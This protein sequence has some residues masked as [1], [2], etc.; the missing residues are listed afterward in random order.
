MVVTSVGGK[1]HR[2][3][4][5]NGCKRKEMLVTWLNKPFVLSGY[6]PIDRIDFLLYIR[7]IPVSNFSPITYYVKEDFIDLF[8]FEFTL[9][10]KL[11]SDI[12][13]HKQVL[14]Y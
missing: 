3:K 2:R 5:E 4:S 6:L 9:K 10:K 11:F 1:W 13:V 7:K 14:R 8:I 12:S